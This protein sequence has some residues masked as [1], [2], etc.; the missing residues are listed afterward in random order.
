MIVNTCYGP[1][2]AVPAQWVPWLWCDAMRSG[3]P[4]RIEACI[5]AAV[6]VLQVATGQ[7]IATLQWTVLA[8]RITA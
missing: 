5:P 4:G 1:E 2:T 6:D 3:N 7:F 8:H